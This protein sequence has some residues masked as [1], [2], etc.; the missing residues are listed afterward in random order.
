MIAKKRKVPPARKPNLHQMA[1]ERRKIVIRQLIQG[2][3][4]KEIIE[5]HGISELV[6][7]GDVERIIMN[8]NLTDRARRRIAKGAYP[9][10]TGSTKMPYK[11]A[12]ARATAE[13]LHKPIKA[14]LEEIKRLKAGISRTTSE[15]RGK[16]IQAK[17]DGILSTM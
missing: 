17:I 1:T 15:T 7:S 2:M 4:R 13:F 8:P 5:F 6:F 14:K 3:T 9:I 16:F 12:E 10:T 11:R